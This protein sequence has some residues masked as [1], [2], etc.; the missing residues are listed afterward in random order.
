M[1]IYPAIDLRGGKV[2]R[3]TEGD[4][5]RQTTFS[6]HPVATAQRWI[7]QGA[8]WLHMVNLDG[9]FDD[10]NDNLTVLANVAKL[11]TQIQFG[12]GLRNMDQIAEALDLGAARVVLG[13]I[14]VKQ[15]DLVAEAVDR[16]GAE[17]IC[18]GLDARDGRITTHGWQATTDMTPVAFGR[19]M[20]ERGVIHALFTDVKRDGTLT[21]ADLAGT[22]ALGEQTSLKVI[23]S[24]GISAVDEIRYLAQS[25]AVAG[26][27]VGMA[28]YRDQINLTEAIDAARDNDAG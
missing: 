25:K 22:I 8:R 10:D 19:K 17:K 16:F 6:D 20:A 5:T 7:D 28:L 21:G 24:G 1:I 13:T 26:V 2:V 12:G 14:A 4:P 9:A 27:I 15:P 18:V 23:A 3:L 11:D